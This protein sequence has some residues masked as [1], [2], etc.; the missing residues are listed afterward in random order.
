MR[1]LGF[2]TVVAALGLAL[3]VSCSSFGG[4]SGCCDPAPTGGS[5]TGGRGAGGMGGAGIGG[6]GCEYQHYFAPGCSGVSPRCTGAG[7]SCATLACGCDGKIIVG[8]G[9]EF[10]TPYAYTVPMSLDGGDLVGGDMVGQTCDPT[11]DAGR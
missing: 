6:A 10:A 5:G 11:S 8:C 2:L 7:G 3:V 4:A 9:P 1:Q